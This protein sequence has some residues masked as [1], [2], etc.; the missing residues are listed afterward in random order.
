MPLAAVRYGVEL[1]RN[2]SWN[3]RPVCGS[4]V[5]SELGQWVQRRDLYSPLEQGPVELETRP[6]TEGA[7]Q[8]RFPTQANLIL[9]ADINKVAQ[10]V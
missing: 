9:R 8:R 6:L 4:I 5:R 10:Y 3:R 2:S 7:T 1:K